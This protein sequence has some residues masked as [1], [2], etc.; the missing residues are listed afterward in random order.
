MSRAL[1]TRRRLPPDLRFAV[2]G[3]IETRTGGYIYDRRLMLELQHLGWAIEHLSWGRG[4]P[5][6]SP[7]EL[8]AAAKTLADLPDG[9]L[10]LVDGL[11]Y[12]AMPALAEAQGGRLRLVS[13]VHHPLALETGLTADRQKMLFES[14]RRALH[15]ARAVVC[16]SATTA[17]TIRQTYGIP[18]NKL[19]IA[20][21][22]TDPM[23]PPVAPAR[24]SDGPVHLLSLASVTHRKGH[25]LLVQG[26]ARLADLDWTCTLAGSLERDPAT[27]G[28][29]RQMIADHGLG[30]RIILAG[31]VAEVSDLYRQAD[32]FVL[33]SRYEGYGMVFAEALQY[34]LPV[35]GT[36]GGA[37]PEVVPPAAG[38]LVPPEDVAALASA[39]RRMIS[40]PA[41]R[42][43]FAAGARAAAQ[44]LPGWQETAQT[45]AAVLQGV[46]SA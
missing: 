45:V 8:V 46:S 15:V 35:I 23:M 41:A 18:S 30:R 34:G 42:R 24:R 22:G 37:I 27:V 14:E 11:A 32:I 10:I 7:A 25:D 2:P 21:P 43:G 36:T 31:E 44:A 40:D 29:V 20:R 19:F 6:P 17:R 39:L 3:N 12:G 38:I 13:L 5:F 9:S 4:F 28:L 26:L 33:A 16:T 1:G